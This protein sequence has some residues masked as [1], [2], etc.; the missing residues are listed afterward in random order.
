MK[1]L[2]RHSAVTCIEQICVGFHMYFHYENGDEEPHVT[3]IARPVTLW[4]GHE[5]L[6]E[7]QI[8]M[9]LIILIELQK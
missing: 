7:I 2:H 8:L 9:I 6:G 5:E 3:G 1:A 4:I